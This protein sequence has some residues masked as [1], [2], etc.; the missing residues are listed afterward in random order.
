MNDVKGEALRLSLQKR[1]TKKQI[2]DKLLGKGF[3]AEESEDAAEYY[4]EAGYIDHRDYARRF[5][6]DAASIK[7]YG[8]G[9]IRRE[10][11][12]RGVEDEYID[13]ALSDII[14]DLKSLMQKK[15]K[16]CKDAKTKNRII[17]CFLRRGFTFDEIKSAIKTVYS[18]EE[19]D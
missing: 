5:A 4:M 11:K 2:V 14:F 12:E 8:P 13:N 15:F 6:N 10:L 19:N 9:R 7:G 3:S 16:E 1:R 17:N 18:G